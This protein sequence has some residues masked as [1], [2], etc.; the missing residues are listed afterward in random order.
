MGDEHDENM[1]EGQ[2][3]PSCLPLPPVPDASFRSHVCKSILKA[4]H[5]HGNQ[6]GGYS[7]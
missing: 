2:L 5:H 3:L 1:K 6:T 4:W 7:R